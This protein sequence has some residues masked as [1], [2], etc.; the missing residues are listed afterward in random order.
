MICQATYDSLDQ[1]P[2]AFRGEFEQ[3][4]GK[5]CLKAD[6]IPGAAELLNPGLAENRDRALDQYKS[7]LTKSQALQTELNQARSEL[8]GLKQPGSTILSGE[9]AKAWQRYVKLGAV[10]DLETIAQQ[11]PKLV[12]QV[13][14]SK[15]IQHL[16]QIA[17]DTGLN[18]EV[19]KDW[20]NMESAQNIEF[21]TKEIDE[22]GQ[23]VKKLFGKRSNEVNGKTEVTEH[24]FDELAGSLPSYMRTALE[25]SGEEKK[26]NQAAPQKGVKVPVLGSTKQAAPGQPEERPV[27]KFNKERATRPNPLRPPAAPQPPA[28]N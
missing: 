25:T 28:G 15:R 17:Q 1:I 11:Y 4:N 8:S 26:E 6:A 2:E 7:E 27:D 22:N 24:S 19:L 23:K 12:A 16:Q 9:D 14:G 18:F 10:K 5:W 13:E 21:F 3:K 20:A